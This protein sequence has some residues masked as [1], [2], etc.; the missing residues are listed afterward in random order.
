MIAGNRY[1]YIRKEYSSEFNRGI[2]FPKSKYRS[3]MKHILT[4]TD[5]SKVAENA[6]EAAFVFAKQ[7]DADLTIY[8]NSVDGDLIMYELVGNP[9]IEHFT[10]NKTIK[11]APITKA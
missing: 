7:Y 4:L 1:L 5:F 8:H 3:H 9:E 2:P 10:L 11:S 6:V